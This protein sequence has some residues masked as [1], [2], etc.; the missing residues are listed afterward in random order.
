LTWSLR[1]PSMKRVGL[2][3]T[4]WPAL[5]AADIDI[6][7]IRISHEAVATTLKFAIQFVQYEIRE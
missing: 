4:R 2:A 1:R 3:M 7:V 5:F 6:A